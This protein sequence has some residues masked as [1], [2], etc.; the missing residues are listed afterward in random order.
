MSKHTIYN[1][2]ACTDI[3]ELR[4]EYKE[5]LECNN[6]SPEEIK[7]FIQD[8]TRLYE[9]ANMILDMNYEDEQSNLNKYVDGNILAIADVGRWNGRVCGYKELSN[10]LKDIF[11]VWDSCERIQLYGENRQIKGTGYH[12]DGT[13]YVIF[14]KLREDITEVQKEKLLSAIYSNEDNAKN[15]IKRY[16]RSIY[17]DIK[18]IYGWN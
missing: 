4:S 16:T 14:R 9:Y 3:E 13:N 6:Y 2:S 18:K 1:N 7:V 10:N 8:E 11:K 17:S 12:H 15:L 5:H